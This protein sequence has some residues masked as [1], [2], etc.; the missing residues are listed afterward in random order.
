MHGLRYRAK[1][2]SNAAHHRDR[3]CVARDELERGARDKHAFA[4]LEKALE[5]ALPVVRC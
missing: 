1:A 3:T 5:K 2:A 4:H